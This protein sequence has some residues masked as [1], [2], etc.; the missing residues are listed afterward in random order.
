MDQTGGVR[1]REIDGRRSSQDAGR[2]VFAAA[3]EGADRALAEEISAEAKWRKRYLGP[4]RRLI[5]SGVRS[6]AAAVGIARAGLEKLHERV[7]FGRDRDAMPLSE[8]VRSNESS[9]FRTETIKGSAASGRPELVIPYRGEDLRGDAIRGQL[10]RWVDAGVIEPSCRD[11][12]EKVVANPDWLDLS[13]RRFVLLGAA[14]EMG[15]LSAL[16]A[17]GADV[18]AI[19][20]PDPRVRERIEQFAREGTGQVSMPVADEETPGADL[21]KHTPEIAAWLRGFDAP[22]TIVDDTYADGSR[23]MLLASATDALMSSLAQQPGV[24][25]AYLATPTDVFA[26]P[27][28]VALG[29]RSRRRAGRG[30]MRALSGG[31]LYRPSYDELV[32]GEDGRRWGIVDCL[33]PQQGANYALAKTLQRWRAVSAREDG[34]VVSANVAPATRTRSVV[35]NKALA[36][37]YRGASAFGIEIFEPETSRW[38]MAALLVHDLRNGSEGAS[39]SEHPYDLHAQG[40]AHAGIW[41]LGYEPRSVLPLA[42]LRGLV[43]RS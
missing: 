39:T 8:A 34:T 43:R 10:D 3:A 24:S 18:I 26:V 22:Y 35:K 7:E 32:T 14:S 4:L 20:L 28:E 31:T 11:A 1:L 2:S 41:R 27:E 33:V 21:L 13:D 19:D 5:E 36:A 25:L 23:F 16:C 30:P 12:V 37:A 42:M 17:W 40:A 29:A 15:A 38:L 9:P 6:R